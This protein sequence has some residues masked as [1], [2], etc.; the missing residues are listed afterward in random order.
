MALCCFLT[1][2]LSCLGDM[3][4]YSES[5][6]NWPTC[7]ERVLILFDTIV[8]LVS[9]I[10]LL[11][12]CRSKVCSLYP[13]HNST[14]VKCVRVLPWIDS[15]SSS[16]VLHTLPLDLIDEVISWLNGRSN[17]VFTERS[18]ANMCWAFTSVYRKHISPIMIDT[19]WQFSSHYNH[20]C[21]W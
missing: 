10:V 19:A 15:E 3:S 7:L 4:Q 9:S 18:L 16:T 13:G 17:C 5:S 1:P 2:Y 12:S 6:F 20:C 8:C 11:W 14:C 21:H